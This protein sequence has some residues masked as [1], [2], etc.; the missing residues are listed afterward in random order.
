[1]LKKAVLIGMVVLAF[2]AGCT[3]SDTAAEKAPDFALQDLS[4]KNV[5]LSDLKGK[6]VL[7]EFWATWCGPCRESIPEM[8]KL[9]KNYRD[10]G[11]VVLGVSMDASGMEVVRSFARDQGISYSVLQGNNEIADQY[12]VR[13]IPVVYL[14]NK[15]G[16]IAR[17]YVGGTDGGIL[18]K[19]IKALL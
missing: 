2:V 9:H 17:H 4:G 14:V 18:E 16:M 15:E 5:R 10:K 13:V 1:M 8:E 11:L 19:D 3:K 6:V 7:L 12:M